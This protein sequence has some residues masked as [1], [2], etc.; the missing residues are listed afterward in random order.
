MKVE[1]K[2]A[3]R[4]ARG[5]GSALKKAN[6]RASRTSRLPGSRQSAQQ[7]LKTVA[8]ESKP[9]N[10]S[11]FDPTTHHAL[12]YNIEGFAIEIR[13]E[14]EG[15][16]NGKILKEDIR[17]PTGWLEDNSGA[18]AN[19]TIFHDAKAQ[20]N[21]QLFRKT[22]VAGQ[23]AFEPHGRKTL[24]K[25][26]ELRKREYCPDPSLDL[27]GDGAVSAQE[28]WIASRFDKDPD[29]VLDG[30][31]R[32]ECLEALRNASEA[33]FKH[34]EAAFAGHASAAQDFEA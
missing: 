31:E 10:G 22:A 5:E 32:K 28:L 14:K 2:T 13:K 23:A 25:L 21:M 12:S 1:T 26:K 18:S 19:R 34:G 29:G 27:N 6:S 24:S 11:A 7:A 30:D 15:I 8:P 9:V 33:R 4:S 17:Y 20:R 16:Q 3:G